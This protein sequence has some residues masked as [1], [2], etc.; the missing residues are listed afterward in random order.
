MLENHEHETNFVTHL[1]RAKPEYKNTFYSVNKIK[2][3]LK[4]FVRMKNNVLSLFKQSLNFSS[5]EQEK[6]ED[7]EDRR[8]HDLRGNDMAARP[9]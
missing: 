7:Q 6:G 4:L 3:L 2:Q 1:Q 5:A 8:Q 9:V